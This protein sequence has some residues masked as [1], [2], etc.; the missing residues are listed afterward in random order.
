MRCLFDIFNFQFLPL[1]F[2]TS[3][4]NAFIAF[5]FLFFSIPHQIIGI[6]KNGKNRINIK[7][8]GANTP[9]SS[10]NSLKFMIPSQ[11]GLNIAFSVSTHINTHAKKASFKLATIRIPVKTKNYST[12]FLYAVV[13]SFT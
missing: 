6:T 3:R 5:L 11:I 2:S 7:I 10:I 4:M 13:N 1:R 8:T 9:L 12:A